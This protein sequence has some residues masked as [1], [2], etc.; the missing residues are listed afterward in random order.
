MIFSNF[1]IIFKDK[2][3]A[4]VPDGVGGAA[5]AALAADERDKRHLGTDGRGRHAPHGRGRFPR[6]RL[7]GALNFLAYTYVY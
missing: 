6:H 5:V 3:G 2:R 4:Q 1:L 7:P